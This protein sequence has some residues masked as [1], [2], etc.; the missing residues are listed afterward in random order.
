M[1]ED[2]KREDKGESKQTLE[3]REERMERL[4][5]ILLDRGEDVAKLV[6]TWLSERD[7]GKE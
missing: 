2:A 6:R 7:G 5:H 3:E 4:K 1:A